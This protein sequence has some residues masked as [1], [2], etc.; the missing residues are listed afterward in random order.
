MISTGIPGLDDVFHGG[1][2]QSNTILVQGAAGTGKSLMG[3]QFIHSGAKQYDEPGI[4]VMFETNPDKLI[5]DA[6]QFGWDL[7]E[8]EKRKK[9]KIIFTNPQVLEAE[10][11]SPNSLLLATA[12]EMG[13]K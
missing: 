4:I 9:L 10:L 3:I 6:A 1:I 11:R 7:P 13:A 5:H 2:P 12:A 8:L